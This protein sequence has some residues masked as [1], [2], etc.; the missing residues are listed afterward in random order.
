M[1]LLTIGMNQMHNNQLSAQEI[2]EISKNAEALR[3]ALE[4]LNGLIKLEAASPKNV[5]YA[6]WLIGALLDDI[7]VNNYYSSELCKRL[8]SAVMSGYFR[9]ILAPYA[10]GI[11]ADRAFRAIEALAKNNASLPF[12]PG[13]VERS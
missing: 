3:E 8:A 5:R 9:S 13:I 11:R 2:Q 1:S 12:V 7:S 6:F 4:T 10:Q